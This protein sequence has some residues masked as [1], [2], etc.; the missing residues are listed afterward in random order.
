MLILSHLFYC[1]VNLDFI[2]NHSSY[3]YSHITLYIT[4]APLKPSPPPLLSPL[5]HLVLTSTSSPLTTFDLW[6]LTRKRQDLIL[7]LSYPSSPTAGP[8]PTIYRALIFSSRRK[9]NT[10]QPVIITLLEEEAPNA[11]HSC[12]MLMYRQTGLFLDEHVL[13]VIYFYMKVY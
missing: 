10:N 13:D 12:Y 9:Q 11:K 1:T 6:F 8:A 5:Y 4:L 2:L 7:T 3:L